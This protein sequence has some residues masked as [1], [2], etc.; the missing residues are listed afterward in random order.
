MNSAVNVHSDG[1]IENRRES[2][3]L[4]SS[5]V[6][7]R[8]G[9][10]TLCAA[11]AV[12]FFS[13]VGD[14]AQAQ[15]IPSFQSLYSFTNGADGGSPYGNLI[16]SNATLYGT[17]SGGGRNGSGTVFALN[18]DGTG[19]RTLYAFSKLVPVPNDPYAAATNIDG[20]NPNGGLVL[21]GDGL[22]GTAAYGGTNGDGTVFAVNTDG[23]GFKI[24]HTF[25]FSDGSLPI[26]LTLSGNRLYGTAFRGGTN[27]GNSGTIFAV[28]TDGTGFTTLHS[29]NLVPDGEDPQCILVLSSNTLYG[30]AL[31][32]GTNDLGI[33]TVFAVNTDGTSFRTVRNFGEFSLSP[34]SGSLQVIM[35]FF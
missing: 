2:C 28:N 30:T 19:F 22:Y 26:G 25:L 6:F 34:P 29:F 14:D 3:N 1:L 5:K 33:G 18:T 7:L 23:T 21:S 10:A 20:A 12:W 16:L 11:A 24:L 15:P 4:V 9:L 13:L 31:D 17:A 27:G 32:G 8:R 35:R